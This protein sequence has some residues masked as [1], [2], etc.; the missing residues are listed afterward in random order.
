MWGWTTGLCL[1]H[2]CR[3]HAPGCVSTRAPEIGARGDGDPSALPTGSERVRRPDPPCQPQHEP[4]S[5]CSPEETMLTRSMG[6]S[7][8]RPPCRRFA[9]PSECFELPSTSSRRMTPR[10]PPNRSP[11]ETSFVDL[12]DVSGFVTG[13]RPDGPS[14]APPPAPSRAPGAFRH[15]SE[16]QDPRLGNFLLRDTSAFVVGAR[17]I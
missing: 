11:S 2:R 5:P 1:F 3:G 14:V 10:F 16:R 13:V 9:M 17:L 8:N 15:P 4:P 7:S 12:D 6:L